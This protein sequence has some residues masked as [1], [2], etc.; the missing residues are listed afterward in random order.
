MQVLKNLWR[1]Y[2][3]LDIMDNKIVLKSDFSIWGSLEIGGK[4]Y[5]ELKGGLEPES[6]S[7]GDHLAKE[8]GFWMI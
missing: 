1:I 5:T 8:R 7:G 6:F 2:I 4:W 3:S